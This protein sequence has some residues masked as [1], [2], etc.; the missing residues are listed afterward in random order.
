MSVELFKQ[1]KKLKKQY[2]QCWRRQLCWTWTKI[3]TR[4][5]FSCEVKAVLASYASTFRNCPATVSAVLNCFATTS[6]DS[7][8]LVSEFSVGTKGGSKS[9][10][11]AKYNLGFEP[12]FESERDLH[13]E[14]QN[15]NLVPERLC[16]NNW[17]APCPVLASCSS[18]DNTIGQH[19]G[20]L[21]SDSAALAQLVLCALCSVHTGQ[22]QQQVE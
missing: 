2:A 9:T 19:F 20:S 22:Q 15:L 14:H 21:S 4:E 11:L 1:I 5:T 12:R 3:K 8:A 18:S 10:C 16:L 17:K 7:A 13:L 6:A